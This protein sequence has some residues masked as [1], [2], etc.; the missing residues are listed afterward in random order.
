[1]LTNVD[2]GRARK[3][4]RKVTA[5]EVRIYHCI[6][7]HFFFGKREREKKENLFGSCSKKQKRHES[8]TFLFSPP[9]QHCF[10]FDKTNGQLMK[11][12]EERM[13]TK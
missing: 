6:V 4:Y 2:Y 10:L 1:M 13:K 12:N 9:L 11:T 8:K 3:E 7:G 5:K